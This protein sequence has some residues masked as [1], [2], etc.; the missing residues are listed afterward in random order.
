MKIAKG[1]LR[2]LDGE[3]KEV[4]FGYSN[5]MYSYMSCGLWISKYVS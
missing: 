3:G 4:C 2:R 5:E 1:G